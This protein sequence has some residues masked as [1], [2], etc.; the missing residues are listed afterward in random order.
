MSGRRRIDCREISGG[1]KQ[2]ERSKGEARVYLGVGEKTGRDVSSRA[3]GKDV[4]GEKGCYPTS[5]DKY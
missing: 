5:V 1:N 4:D 3:R 2:I